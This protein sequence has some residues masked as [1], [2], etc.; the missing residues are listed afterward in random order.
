MEIEELIKKQKEFF[1]TNKTKDIKFRKD[2]L[3]KLRNAIL[4]YEKDIEIAIRKDLNKSS[5][6]SYMV[7]IGICLSEISYM[8]KHIGKWS[9]EKRVLTPI[10]QFHAKS[11]ES[12]EPYGTVLIISPWN[13]PFMLSID[14]LID[15]ISAGNCVI[16]KPSEFSPNTSLIMEKIIKEIFDEEFV[17]VVQGDKDVCTKLLEQKV[18]YIFYTGGNRVGKIVMQEAAK[19]LI[20]VTLELGGKSPCIVDKAANLEIAAKRILFGKI[21]NAGQTCVAPDYLLVQKDVKEKL[22]SYFIKYIREFLGNEPIENQNYAHII[23][24]RHFKRI[25]NLLEGEKI[26]IGGK[27]NKEERII[28][29]TFVDGNFSKKELLEEEIFGPIMPVFTYNNIDEAINFVKQKEKPLAFYLFTADKKIEK[30]VLNEISF[31]GGCI[32]D[33][34]IHLATSR[35]GFGGVGNSGMGAYHG[36]KGFDTFTHYRS[37]VKK[38]TW[39]DLPMRYMPYTKIKDKM[40]RTFLR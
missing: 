6:E 19:N 11:F 12:P 30:K 28:E 29:P 31:G 36:K 22:I 5:S 8:L 24:D 27:I 33:T 32:N 2:A 7:E 4:K 1:N 35:L 15:A 14:P 25:M 37:I 39:I 23:N 9:K 21:L 18:D 20:P 38:Y 16:L 40:I 26:L 13:Y 3:R 10:S 17:S 34:I